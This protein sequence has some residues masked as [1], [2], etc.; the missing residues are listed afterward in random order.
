MSEPFSRLYLL[1]NHWSSSSKLIK[2]SLSETPALQAGEEKALPLARQ[3]LP[4]AQKLAMSLTSWIHFL[5]SKKT[6]S[7]ESNGCALL[8]L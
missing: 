7:M 5:W 8:G 6:L 2:P 3:L 4:T 1:S